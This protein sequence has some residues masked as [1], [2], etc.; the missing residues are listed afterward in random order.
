M[1]APAY[2]IGMADS[3][4]SNTLSGSTLFLAASTTGMI[5]P[6]LSFWLTHDLRNAPRQG[7]LDPHG[8]TLNALVRAGFFSTRV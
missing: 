6:A 3:D 7:I 8:K 4:F 5:P 1:A 2:L